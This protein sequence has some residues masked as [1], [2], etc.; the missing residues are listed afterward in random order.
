MR[1]ASMIVIHELPKKPKEKASQNTSVRW[2]ERREHR[3]EGAHG[4]G[5]NRM[6]HP[7][8]AQAIQA[9][10]QL[11]TQ[12]RFCEAE[13]VLAETLADGVEDAEIRKA[14]VELRSQCLAVHGSRLMMPKDSHPVRIAAMI[15]AR[16][17]TLPAGTPLPYGRWR[18][19][20]TAASC[21]RSGGG[22]GAGNGTEAEE[23][24]GA[25]DDDDSGSCLLDAKET[26]QLQQWDICMLICIAY[27]GESAACLPEL[28]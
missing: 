27:V 9:S 11:L 10:R 21:S 20:N 26:P 24:E 28:I 16:R 12:G 18:G 8:Q 14:A 15:K 17:S 3:R 23:D 13:Q 25:Q 2:R 5:P 22:A 7:D 6:G 19:G 4:A 1:S